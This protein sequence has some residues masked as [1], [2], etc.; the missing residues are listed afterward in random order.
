MHTPMPR[1]WRGASIR[2]FEAGRF[3]DFAFRFAARNASLRP[4][5]PT[6]SIVETS[7]NVVIVIGTDTHTLSIGGVS[8][9]PLSGGA[10]I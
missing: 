9:R 1:L 10:V 4:R 6:H 3:I 8:P 7:I 2:G 5:A